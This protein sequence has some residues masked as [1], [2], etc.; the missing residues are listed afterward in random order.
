MGEDTYGILDVLARGGGV[1]SYFYFSR[2]S[3]YAKHPDDPAFFFDPV[4]MTPKI[5]SPAFVR[6][7][8]DMIAAVPWAPP[9]QA[10]ADLLKTLGDF[11]AGYGL[12]GT[13]V[14]G[15]RF[16]RLFQPR[17][18]RA[19]QGWIQHPAGF[20]RC[21]QLG[22]PA[23]GTPSPARCAG[24]DGRV[25]LRALSRLPRLG[26]LRDESRRRARC[27]RSRLG[28]HQAT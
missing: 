21:L 26:S 14:G 24:R 8:D 5:N 25:Q 16:Q 28:P 23:N 15:Y 6:A 12:D 18:D 10:N 27:L 4:D 1:G 11:L 19:G 20:A 9:D 3:A 13:L 2:A 17:L 7:L 22:D